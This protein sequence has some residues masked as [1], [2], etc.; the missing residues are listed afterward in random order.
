LTISNPNKAAE[1]V[2]EPFTAMG[3]LGEM[4]D[5]ESI[6]LLVEKFDYMGEYANLALSKI[7][8]KAIPAIVEL[9]RKDDGIHHNNGRWALSNIE[10][11]EAKSDLMYLV[12]NDTDIEIRK[13]ALNSL[14][15]FMYDDDVLILSE[16]LFRKNKTG[17]YM[18]AMK[19]RK[20]VP[21]LIRILN[22]IYENE[23]NRW[24]AAYLLGEIGDTTAIPALEEAY[25]K[26]DRAVGGSA[27]EALKRITGKSYPWRWGN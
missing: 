13:C 17:I 12:E 14:V 8:K 5:E 3:A 4:K 25:S 7:G 24:Y 20:A 9:A 10:D 16:N 21:F 19:N 15:R 18:D 1:M 23:D 6:P 22:D 11:K 2:L 27:C 26:G